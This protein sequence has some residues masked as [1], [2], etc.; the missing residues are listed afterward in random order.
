MYSRNAVFA[1]AAALVLG[2]PEAYAKNE[3]KPQAQGISQTDKVCE[4]ELR[5]GIQRMIRDAK[6]LHQNSTEETLNET[7]RALET[8]SKISD[9]TKE[10]NV[11]ILGIDQIM[12]RSKVPQQCKGYVEQRL[13]KLPVADPA[14]QACEFALEGAVTI[15]LN[16]EKNSGNKKMVDTLTD[17]STALVNTD[18]VILVPPEKENYIKLALIE[19]LEWIP[20]NCQSPAQ[21]RLVGL[22][23]EL[24]ARINFKGSG[25]FVNPMTLAL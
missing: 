14:E 9:V 22:P 10:V 3:P 18:H 13:D 19:I 25:Q 20:E 21:Q 23:H 7:L 16:T 24:E 8:G 17:I 4:G 1:A 2:Q 11:K 6:E 15:A 5:Q 12:S